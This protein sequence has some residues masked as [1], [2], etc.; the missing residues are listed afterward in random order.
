MVASGT[1][2]AGRRTCAAGSGTISNPCKAKSTGSAAPSHAI[3]T[4]AAR[5]PAIGVGDKRGRSE[6][7]AEVSAAMGSASSGSDLSTVMEDHA[8]AARR[9]PNESAAVSVVRS[10]SS[11]V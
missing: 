3:L 2:R 4:G 1:S 5:G 10:A 6:L 9:S 8:M 7:R 11:M